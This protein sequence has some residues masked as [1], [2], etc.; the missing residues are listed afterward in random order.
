[1]AKDEIKKILRNV[2]CKGDISELEEMLDSE[3]N[4]DILQVLYMVFV[5]FDDMKAQLEELEEKN[6]DLQRKILFLNEKVDFLTERMT[7][8]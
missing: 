4:E 8:K 3:S 7:E 5:V 1:M 6:D 2:F